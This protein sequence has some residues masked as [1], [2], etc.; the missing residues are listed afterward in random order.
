MD[1]QWPAPKPV[2][3]VGH[4]KEKQNSS[5]GQTGMSTEM[6]RVMLKS[7]CVWLQLFAYQEDSSEPARNVDE[8]HLRL[9]GVFDLFVSAMMRK[10]D[11]EP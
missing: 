3:I 7:S 8:W 2:Y 10:R 9:A 11:A 1:R 6:T 5:D 4:H